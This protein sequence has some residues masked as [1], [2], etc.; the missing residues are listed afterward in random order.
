MDPSGRGVGEG[1]GGVKGEETVSMINNVR[2]KTH[3][4]KGGNSRKVWEL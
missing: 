3:F 1:L 2:K 4:N